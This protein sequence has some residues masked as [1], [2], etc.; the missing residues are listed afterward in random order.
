MLLT[1]AP[2]LQ[3]SS[4]LLIATL[5]VGW[6]KKRTAKH[7][8]A[9]VLWFWKNSQRFPATYKSLGDR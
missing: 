5:I 9:W 7:I 2:P 1:A 6:V 3:S 8:V 4:D